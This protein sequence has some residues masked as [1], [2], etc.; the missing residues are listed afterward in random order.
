MNYVVDIIGE[1][2]AAMR[3][4]SELDELFHESLAGMIPFYLYGHKLDIAN[5]L[6]LKNND[7]KFKDQKYPLI[8]LIMDFPE[9]VAGGMAH[10]SLHVVILHLTDPNFTIED[11]YEQVFRPILYPL[12]EKFMVQLRKVGKFT[13]AGDQGFPDHIKTDRPYWG[14]V[15]E[16]GNAA[17]IFND[18]LDALEIAELKIS[19]TIKN[20]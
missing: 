20:C 10:Y 3:N 14:K 11:R 7:A 4:D 6:L 1:V 9:H 8:A 18:R 16:Q 15:Y 2:V 5:R 13:W 12:Y 19:K 17:Y